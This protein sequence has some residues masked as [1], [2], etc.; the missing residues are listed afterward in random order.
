M[1]QTTIKTHLFAIGIDEHTLLVA[2]GKIGI[3]RG[4]LVT[5]ADVDIMV[6]SKSCARYGI[7]PVGIIA[8]IG[9]V[10][11]ARTDIGTIH[12]VEFLAECS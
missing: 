9:I 11:L 7:Q 6:M 1:A 5:T 3:V 4:T 10:G 2:I 8:A 12:H